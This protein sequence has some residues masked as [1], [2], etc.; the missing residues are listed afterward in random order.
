MHLIDGEY[1][2]HPFYGGRRM[3]VWLA[4]QGHA[5]DRKTARKLMQRMGLEAI[6]PKPNLSVPAPNHKVF[7]Y[8]LRGVVASRPN[9]IWSI[10]ITYIRLRGGFLYLVAII[11]WYS[12]YVV[13]WE[14]SNTLEATFCDI[15]LNRA[16]EQFGTPEIFNSDQGCQFTRK[17]FTDMLQARGIR[18][19]MDGRGRAIDNIFIERLWRSVKYEEVYPRGYEDGLDAFRGLERYFSF[20]N[21]E[22]PHQSLNYK[23]PASLYRRCA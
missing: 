11:D 1:T 7:P 2:R 17:D 14:L 9:H 10:D 12:R 20:Y 15:V 18:V 22:R 16:L 19:S 8:L 6:Y 13:S 21:H 23:A 3:A 4:K 5:I